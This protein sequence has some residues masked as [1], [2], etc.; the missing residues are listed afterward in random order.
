MAK[1]G[2]LEMLTMEYV[3]SLAMPKLDCLKCEVPRTL[4]QKGASSRVLV[5]IGDA[6][7]AVNHIPPSPQI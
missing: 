4:L 5:E 6:L 3:V 1:G 2:F 7:V